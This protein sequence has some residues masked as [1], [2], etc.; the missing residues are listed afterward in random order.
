MKGRRD[1]QTETETDKQAGRQAS[2][3]RNKLGNRY[4]TYI[5]TDRNRTAETDRQKYIQTERDRDRQTESETGL[6]DRQTSLARWNHGRRDYRITQL[7]GFY[8]C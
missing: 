3:D 2:G 4:N 7:N 8:S 1:R 6:R 5:Q